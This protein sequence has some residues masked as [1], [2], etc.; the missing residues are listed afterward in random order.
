MDIV[1][2]SIKKPVTIL[3]G[4]ILVVLFGIIS[5]QTLPYQ[6]SP[7]VVEPI[8][9]VTTTWRGA[10][11]YEMEREI[12]EEQEK[13]LKGIPGLAEM[14]SEAF[15]SQ[16]NISLTFKL[17]TNVD[18][19][20]L[21]VSNKLNEVPSY[22]EGVDKPIINAT[23][24][25]TSPV[26]WIILKSDEDN[27]RHIE[28][29]RT[30][31]ENEIRQHLERV[32]GV[33]DLFIG[34]GVDEEMHIIVKPERLAA[35]GLTINDVING[36]RGENVNVS[37]GNMGV[38]R[39]DFRIRTTGEFNS[40]AEI[41]N[42]VLVSTGEKRVTLGD[43]A[44]VE[45]GYSK[46]EST[47]IHNGKGGMAVGIK[48]EPG[49]NILAMTERVEEVVK[50]LNV[51][52]LAPQNISFQWV[53]DQR[54]YINAAIDL[55]KQNILIGGMLAVIV[56]LIFLR[57]IRST[58][59]V[60]T[61][62]PISIIG[63]FIFMQAMG[64]N[65]NVVS[66]AGIAFAVGML[67]DNAIVVIENIDRH[68]KMGKSAFAASYEGTREVWGAIIAS[69]LTTVAVFLPV[70]F[71]QEE[72]GQL[73]RDIAI[74]VVAAVSLSLVVSMT[75]IPMFSYKLFSVSAKKV[76]KTGG[77]LGRLG[78]RL[79]SALMHI[80]SLATK[81][82]A[83]RIGTVLL[84][85]L[86]A[87]GSVFL[88]MPQT[89]YLPQGNRN[90]VLSILVPPP[91]L[92][93]H[94]RQ[95]IG[96]KL[97]AMAEPHMKQEHEG[98][99]GILNM[100]YVARESIMLFG[101]MSTDW[102]RAAD[103]LPLFRRMIYSIPGMF[104]V[105]MQVGIFQSRIGRS[106]T[107]DVD[108]SG[109]DLDQ[110]VKV[111][112][113]MFGKA[114][115]VMPDTQVRPIPSIELSYPEVKIIPNR[116]RLKANNM[117]AADLGIALDVLMDGRIVGD[118]KQEGKKTIDLVL[119][120]DDELINTPEALYHSLIATPGGKIVP[121][122]SLADLERTTGMTQIRHLERSRT[123]TLQMTPPLNIPLQTAMEE[124]EAKIINPV[125][126]LG[127]LKGLGV[128]M[129][130]AADKLTETREALKWNFI[131]AA[132]IAYLLMASLFGNFI[133]PLI[134]ML[135]VPL[136]GAGGFI[137]LKLLNLLSST[138]QPMDILT[139]LG[140]VI[141]IGIVVNNA[142]LIVHQALNN[143]H[144]NN[145]E[146]R[147]AVLESTKSR[148]R[149]IYMSATTSVFGM[150][151]LVLFPGSGSELYR[152]LGSVI[153]GGLAISTIFTVFVIPSILIFVIRMEKPHGLGPEK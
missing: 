143:V 61:S 92:S 97:F 132:A 1:S 37:A 40:E 54:R 26:I 123:V 67:V 13:T 141:L 36:V 4:I 93:Q 85:I 131:L 111:A 135:T 65:L 22:P 33:A 21:R 144:H 107:V 134:I 47:V 15:N 153:I 109:D 74:A 30:F 86:L 126:D 38:G 150:L 96:E 44:E 32:E 146:Y 78:T 19:A 51:E 49:T 119:K 89:D 60:A 129:S 9:T 52:K 83:T 48:P 14:E 27:P 95:D 24:A 82:W 142:I 42:V 116:E 99:P 113:M 50:W 117:S 106:R 69:T 23:G 127:L 62:I 68:R 25:A 98:L 88:L 138:P 59:V 122:S 11:P 70:V 46:R 81:N 133:Y 137:G 114:K 7:T 6:L 100:F 20:L 41:A 45:H 10:T 148:L 57:S 35:Y 55:I 66:L 136:A 108:I 84:L 103:L 115:Q 17:G 3:V 12:I 152:G 8:I 151:P 90:F 2:F 118:Y 149:P 94:E 43:V 76:K 56:L 102:E 120:T 79:A 77:L 80:V 16:G 73:F 121:V 140:F 110:I 63:T 105:S 71:I 31:F 18:E 28:T 87:V 139:M 75:V 128:R 91:G 5:L 39:R 112:G 145:M 53:Y 130:G 125:R 72:A 64:R 101:A 147:E 104:G 58:L 124:I 34:S 29:Y